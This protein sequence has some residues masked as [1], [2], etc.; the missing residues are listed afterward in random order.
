MWWNRKLEVL[1]GCEVWE[2]DDVAI[3]AAS[4]LDS[5]RCMIPAWYSGDTGV[6]S[7]WY[8]CDTRGGAYLVKW[9]GSWSCVVTVGKNVMKSAVWGACKLVWMAAGRLPLQVKL[10]CHGNWQ[11]VAGAA[12]DD[13]R[14]RVESAVEARVAAWA[15]VK[16]GAMLIVQPES[17]VQFL[18]GG[19]KFV[20]SCGK[21]EIMRALGFE[22][23]VDSFLM[24]AK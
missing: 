8:W 20:T 3:M 24:T 17:L 1:V 13:H 14:M 21:L 18:C 23:Y 6:V 22:K 11:M 4:I 10:E 9:T 2:V 16:V 15:G 19:G 12:P 5:F 7:G